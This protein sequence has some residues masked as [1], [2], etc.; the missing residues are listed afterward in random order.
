M[1]VYT[2]NGDGDL[3]AEEEEDFECDNCFKKLTLSDLIAFDDNCPNCLE[4]IDKEYLAESIVSMEFGSSSED[5]V[6]GEDIGDSGTWLLCCGV[7]ADDCECDES[8]KGPTFDD[9]LDT[10]VPLLPKDMYLEEYPGVCSRCALMYTG[11]CGPLSETLYVLYM[12]SSDP[13]SDPYLGQIDGCLNYTKL[14]EED[15]Y[16][17]QVRVNIRRKHT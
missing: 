14:T 15:K 16:V 4:P 11:L 5:E 9:A 1:G 13:S 12:K 10:Y 2:L 7:E 8:L 17:R 3:E 6:R